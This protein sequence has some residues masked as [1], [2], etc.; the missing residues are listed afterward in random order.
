MPNSDDNPSSLK[1][2]DNIDVKTPLKS[3]ERCKNLEKQVELLEKAIANLHEDDK[4]RKTLMET[5]KEEKLKNENAILA[6]EKEAR[7]NLMPKRK[8]PAKK[9]ASLIKPMGKRIR[10]VQRTLL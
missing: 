2:W 7:Q 5:A 3:E 8:T 4:R 6:A 10:E 9:K 1:P